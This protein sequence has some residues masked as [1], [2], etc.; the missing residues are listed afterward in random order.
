MTELTIREAA[1]ALDNSEYREEGTIDLFKRM[2]D[3]SLVAVFGASD[4]LTELRGA[5]YDETGGSKFYL[6]QSGL[7]TSECDEGED[8]P[9]FKAMLK[10][11]S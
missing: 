7:L 10:T 2:R 4:D 6:D 8:C 11:I 5:I 9:Y 1:Q 3:C